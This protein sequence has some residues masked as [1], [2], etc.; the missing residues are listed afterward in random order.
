MKSVIGFAALAL[1]TFVGSR[2]AHAYPPQ[3]TAQFGYAASCC[4]SSYARNAEGT[5]DNGQR[6]AELA[7]C[8]AKQPSK[9]K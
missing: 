9:K 6:H 1:V 4:A 3:C 5:M 8:T 2:A 7:A